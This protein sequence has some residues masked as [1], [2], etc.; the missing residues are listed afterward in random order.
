MSKRKILRAASRKGI[1]FDELYFNRQCVTP[2]EIVSAWDIRLSEE[3][4][5]AIAD[6]D[7]SFTNFTPDVWNTRMVL[8]WIDSLP[9]LIATGAAP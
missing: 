5:N 9:D 7:P 4:E 6:A 3:S 2:E 8:E 1:T